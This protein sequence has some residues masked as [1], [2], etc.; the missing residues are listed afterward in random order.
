M[1]L[2]TVAR[3]AP[4][5]L[6]FSRQEYC[7]GSPFPPPGDLPNPGIKV[8]SAALQ[9]G[10]LPRK[11][12]LYGWASR[13]AP[14]FS[15]KEAK[16]RNTA[17]FHPPMSCVL[18]DCSELWHELHQSSSRTCSLT[19]LSVL[20]KDEP[21]SINTGPSVLSPL[22]MPFSLHPL[23]FNQLFATHVNGRLNSSLHNPNAQ[24]P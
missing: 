6:G 13:E 22:L 16:E 3:Q 14:S 4:L 18:L 17:S 23:R 10:L 9:A 8:P 5:S 2:W 15:E 11:R 12:I 1:T 21:T 19:Q 20:L 7:S 24:I